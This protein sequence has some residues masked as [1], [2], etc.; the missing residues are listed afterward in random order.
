[1]HV[2]RGRRLRRVAVA[3]RVDPDDAGALPGAIEPSDGADRDGVIAAE[4]EREVPGLRDV[5]DDLREL[6]RGADDLLDVVRLRPSA[7]TIDLLVLVRGAPLVRILHAHVAAIAYAVADLGQLH[8]EA[9]VADAGRSHVDAAAIPAEV[10][11]HADDLDGLH[12]FF[13]NTP[14]ITP[15]AASSS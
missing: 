2:A 1:M 7:D 13:W 10:H 12:L 15:S 8:R 11:R 5:L 6:L 14:R 3:V 9:G 4:H